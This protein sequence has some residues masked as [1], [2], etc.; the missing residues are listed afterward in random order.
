MEAGGSFGAQF[1]PYIAAFKAGDPGTDHEFIALLKKAGNEDPLMMD[2]Q[3][4]MFDD[5]I[6]GPAF[7]WAAKYE[8]TL[9][10][11]YLTIADSFLHW[12]DVPLVDGSVRGKEAF[13]RWRRKSLD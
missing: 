12:H 6:L 8:F 10:L 1:A 2:V 3:E 13:R 11:S 4:E 7:E 5:F 9:P